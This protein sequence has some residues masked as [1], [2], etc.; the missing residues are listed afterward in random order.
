M[1]CK[2]NIIIHHY[3]FTV[4]YGTFLG[5]LGFQSGHLDGFMGFFMFFYEMGP[6]EWENQVNLT[7]QYANQVSVDS[8]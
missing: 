7:L 3:Q 4:F 8:M 6:R 5:L 1:T 2:N